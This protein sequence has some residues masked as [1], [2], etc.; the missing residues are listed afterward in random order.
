MNADAVTVR[1]KNH[2]HAANLRGQLL[3][4]ELH[5]VLFQMR[6]RGVEILLA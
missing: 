2:R 6:D 4:A 1:I 3:D 5:I